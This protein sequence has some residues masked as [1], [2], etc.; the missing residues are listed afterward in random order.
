[1]RIHPVTLILLSFSLGCSLV[2]RHELKERE[3]QR[4]TATASAIEP[5]AEPPLIEESR[6]V[7]AEEILDEELPQAQVESV[8]QVSK[9]IHQI[10]FES[11][12][13]VQ[14]WIEYFSQKDRARFQRFLD[15]GAKYREVVEN[16]LKENGLPA[17]LYY[18][19]M[20]ESGYQN[21]ATSIAAAVGVWQFIPGTATRYGLE[22]SRTVDERRDPIR[23]TEAAVRYLKDLHN[24]FGSWHLAMAG[25][26]AGEYRV[27]R[28][29]FKGKTRDFWKLNELKALPPET[30]NYIPKFLAAVEI[31]QNPLKYGFTTPLG[32][33][34]PDLQAVKLANGLSL[35]EIAKTSGISF[36]ELKKVNPH[37]TQGITPYGQDGYEVWVPLQLK[38]Q[39]PHLL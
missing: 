15:R 13:D 20:I 18:L 22:V 1:V 19:A 10:P 25:Y 37:L 39:N 26:N 33:R 35:K 3:N 8:K 16:V 23:A 7:E 29:V 11:N 34:Y 2:S 30:R 6:V 24:V 28:A 31:G 27:V 21:H 12:K 9:S 32:E 36:A 38:N 17:E 14:K 4:E 5:S